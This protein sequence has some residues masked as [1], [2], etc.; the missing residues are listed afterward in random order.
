MGRGDQQPPLY[1]TPCRDG[2]GH[3]EDK[4]K[5]ILITGKPLPKKT[6][7][8]MKRAES[9]TPG[10]RRHARTQDTSTYQVG[11]GLVR[12]KVN[13]EILQTVFGEALKTSIAVYNSPQEW[14][15]LLF[16]DSD[17]EGEKKGQSKDDADLIGTDQTTWKLQETDQVVY[18]EK[19]M[20]RW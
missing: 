11:D 4:D 3:A 15:G 18:S 20:V 5:M 12:G 9:S 2:S 19:K 10:A 14:D 13:R 16:S 17:D 6:W 7:R 1:R 8:R